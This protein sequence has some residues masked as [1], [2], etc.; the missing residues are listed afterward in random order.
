MTRFRPFSNDSNNNNRSSPFKG[1]QSRPYD[2]TT[3][4]C[5]EENL[6]IASLIQTMMTTTITPPESTLS[7]TRHGSGSGSRNT[8]AMQSSRGNDSESSADGIKSR[9][10]ATSN[11]QNPRTFLSKRL[12]KMQRRKQG[13]GTNALSSLNEQPTRR[14]SRS[15]HSPTTCPRLS[16]SSK[17]AETANQ[18]APKYLLFFRKHRKPWSTLHVGHNTQQAQSPESDGRSG[19]KLS[20]SPS[21]LRRPSLTLEGHTKNTYSAPRPAKRFGNMQQENA[22]SGS[23]GTLPMRSDRDKGITTTT[24][25]TTGDTDSVTDEADTMAE[26]AVMAEGDSTAEDAA[27]ASN[28]TTQITTATTGT[29]TTGNRDRETSSLPKSLQGRT[30][31]TALSLLASDHRRHMDITHYRGGGTTRSGRR[32]LMHPRTAAH[33]T[34]P[35][36]QHNLGQ[37]PRG[38]AVTRRD[39]GSTSN[40]GGIDEMLQLFYSTSGYEGPPLL[41]LH[42]TKFAHPLRE[43]Q[44]GRSPSTTTYYPPERLAY[45]DGHLVG[46]QCFGSM[47]TTTKSHRLSLAGSFIPP[48][49]SLLWDLITPTDILQG[50]E[51]GTCIPTETGDPMRLLYRRH[52]RPGPHKR[53]SGVPYTP[54]TTSPY[55]AW[56]YH[57]RQE[58]LQLS[59]PDSGI[60]R[61]PDQDTHTINMPTIAK[62]AGDSTR[63]KMV[64]FTTHHYDSQVGIVPWPT[65]SNGPSSMAMATK[66]TGDRASDNRRAGQLESRLGS[67]GPPSNNGFQGIWMV[68]K[69]IAD[70]EWP[71]IAP[72]HSRPPLSDRD[73]CVQ[74]WVGNS[75]TSE[76]DPGQ[77]DPVGTATIVE[78]SRNEDSIIRRPDLPTQVGKQVHPTGDRQH[79]D[80]GLHQ[81][82]GGDALPEAPSTCN[83]TM[84]HMPETTDQHSSEIPSREGQ[85]GSRHSLARDGGSTCM[86]APTTSLSVDRTIM[87]SPSNRPICR[88][89]HN[90]S[91]GIFQPVPGSISDSNRRFP[92]TLATS[93]SIRIPTMGPDRTSTPPDFSPEDTGI[94][95]SNTGLANTT[96]VSDAT[97]DVAHAPIIPAT[98]HIQL[99][100]NQHSMPSNTQP[101]STRHSRMANI[102]QAMEMIG[103]DADTAA[104]MAAPKRHKT[105]V[106]YDSSFRLFSRWC[107][108]KGHD[109]HT[110]NI[111]NL[112]NYLGWMSRQQQYSS[113]RSLHAHRSAISS[114][115]SQLHPNIPAAGDNT[116]VAKLLERLKDT[117]LT[118]PPTPQS[119]RV[120]KVLTYLATIDETSASLLD[121]TRKLVSLIILGSGWRPASDM[122]RILLPEG[123]TDG[124]QV[125]LTV[126]KPKEGDFKHITFTEWTAHRSLCVVRLLRHYLQLTTN[127]RP[128]VPSGARAYLFL[129]SRKP[130]NHASEPTCAGWF[131]HVLSAS[132]INAKP[133]SARGV[134]NSTALANGIPLCQIIQTANWSSAE[135]FRRHYLRELPN[136]TPM[137]EARIS[138][139]IPR[140]RR[141]QHTITQGYQLSTLQSQH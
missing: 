31:P 105:G 138:Q 107:E 127:I 41:E 109:P 88:Q 140:K 102:M 14:S 73:R 16:T 89:V 122:G 128:S 79:N 108:D 125:I 29:E 71:V 50:D 87:G 70:V 30:N 8:R 135:T 94:G 116:L 12:A 68:G 47:P 97:T 82:D 27:P 15:S 93:R 57:Q 61:I 37:E 46:L 103:L 112:M 42:T 32:P 39:R 72:I 98:R 48:P 44:N 106:N 133:H 120:D 9:K 124:T 22:P 110:H 130:Y 74:T 75:R 115:W 92:T 54:T 10:E 99:S 5:V 2:S 25:I 90:T 59:G 33:P 77:L 111:A 101:R 52:T 6:P 4:T 17:K 3:T 126:F 23:N 60:F 63:S 113:I 38:H 69:G 117:L 123:P 114:T 78:L 51:D 129:T 58:I 36:G 62:G 100:G 132:G 119:W 85:C 20:D 19:Q 67:N 131:R 40:G 141:R 1:R 28:P 118:P 21:N 34:Q 134:V 45:Q 137:E 104:T 81:Q 84:G 43:I 64:G 83:G 35:N 86:E 136:A 55:P 66:T 80:C 24:A 76:D 139:I 56:L 91:H 95:P 11:R 121:I 7:Q 26:D 53:K 96:M 13:N 49:S 65:R 18:A